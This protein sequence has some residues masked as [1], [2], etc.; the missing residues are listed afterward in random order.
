MNEHER[1]SSTPARP[2]HPLL[3][4]LLLIGGTFF[5]ILGSLGAFLPVLP[6]TPFFLLAAALFFRSSPRLYGWMTGHPLIKPH[7]QRFQQDRSMTLRA[8]ATVLGLAWMML[9]AAAIFAVD[10][11]FMRAFLVGL[12]IIKTVVILRLKTARSPS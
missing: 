10:S 7:L 11:P 1:L 6:S 9:L 5:L 3:R 2:S 8:K 4:P 12:A